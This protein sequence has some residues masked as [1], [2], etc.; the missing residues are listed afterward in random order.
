MLAVSLSELGLNPSYAI[1]GDL[2]AP[3]SNALH[4]AA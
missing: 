4:G 3:G 1:G 2:D